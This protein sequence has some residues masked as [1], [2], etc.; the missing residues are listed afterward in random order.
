MHRTDMIS[1]NFQETI[2]PSVPRPYP[3]QLLIK[4]R[5]GHRCAV[6]LETQ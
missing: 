2:L 5:K 3:K 4:L 6:G 1:F